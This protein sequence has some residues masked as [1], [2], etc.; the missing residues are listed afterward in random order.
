MTSS[1]SPVSTV[2]PDLPGIDHP[3][4][5][6]PL[7]DHANVSTSRRLG[8]HLPTHTPAVQNDLPKIADR[9]D[10]ISIPES[11]SGEWSG[12]PFERTVGTSEID[13]ALDRYAGC[14]SIISRSSTYTISR[15]HLQE[16]Q[17]PPDP[18]S[19]TSRE[20]TPSYQPSNH[21]YKSSFST[22]ANHI[23]DAPASSWRGKNRSNSQGAKSGLSGKSGMTRKS[24][25]S[26]L[27]NKDLQN[28]SVLCLSSSDDESEEDLDTPTAELPTFDKSRDYRDSVATYGE[29]PEVY[30][31]ATALAGTSHLLKMNLENLTSM[32]GESRRTTRQQHTRTHSSN[33]STSTTRTGSTSR[34]INKS[35]RTSAI[36]AILQPPDRPAQKPAR[37]AKESRDINR[38]S[39]V[40]AVTRQEQDLLEA[41][42]QRQG[43]ITP[44][45]FNYNPNTES[46]HASVLSGPCRDSFCGSD[47]S[48]LRLSAALPPSAR[49]DQGA[50]LLD[51]DG[52]SWQSSS[53]DS[54]QKTGNSV[55]SS[56]YSIHY[57][58]SIPSPATSAASPI[59]PTLPLHR[60]SPLPGPKPPPRGPPP[61]IPDDQKRHSRRRTD[62]S[63]AIM[64]TENGDE[65]QAK[66]G[67]PIWPVDLEWNRDHG[68]LAA[69][70]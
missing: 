56:Q 43:K 16:P 10:L 20:L 11:K 2:V 68:N 69:V 25:K 26:T 70:H 36:P 55:A 15:E 66:Q 8:E 49:M 5:E 50:H 3:R 27:Q 48:F 4:F 14:R 59:T 12:A 42:R 28:T 57:S 6:P 47:T 7:F 53:S 38:R 30:T 31:A 9:S 21:Q 33:P 41:M 44:S 39:R 54:E 58:D 22:E 64:L 34:R 35:P 13:I 32:R 52:T 40:I 60:M 17:P 1:P 62:S 67:I 19:H 65:T 46:D 63:D 23:T 45:I 29:E 51:K 61:A 24:S 18:R 37:T